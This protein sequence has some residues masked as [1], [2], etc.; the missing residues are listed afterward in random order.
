MHNPEAGRGA[1][2]KKDLVAA[3]T[4]AGH[5]V[6]YQSTKERDYKQALKKKTDLVVVAGGDGTVGKIARQLLDTGIPLSVL[7]LG[8]ANNVARTLGF[9]ATPEEIITQL[10]KGKQHAVDVGIAIGPWGKHYL[11]EGA[12]GGLLADYFEDA[13]RRAKEK[14]EAAKTSGEE[15]MTRHVSL[16]RRMLQEFPARCWKIEIDGEDI[17][18][19]FILWEAMNI[20]SVGPVLYLAPHAGTKD[21]RFD[22]VSVGERD[23]SLLMAHL[24]ARLAGK[25]SLYSLPTRR[26]SKLRVTWEGS[27][28]HI[29]DNLWPAEQRR[30]QKSIRFTITVK[31]SA[32]VILRPAA[33]RARS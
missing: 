24:D 20:R 14:K 4:K 3:L 12:G 29:D 30:P 25:K 15:E 23:R 32:L 13:N 19:S 7:P 27:T 6:I 33:R 2:S 18:G 1:H 16:L 10:E 31:P 28:I 11:F 8:T 26:F 9:T 21:G 22:F 17:S 5:R